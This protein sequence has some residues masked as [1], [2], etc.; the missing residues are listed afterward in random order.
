MLEVLGFL[1]C[2][3]AVLNPE[4]V[5]MF[6]NGSDSWR[7]KRVVVGGKSPYTWGYSLNC[8]NEDEGCVALWREG[9]EG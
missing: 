4:L 6:I 8:V 2:G 3:G 9:F 1:T 7:W 5:N